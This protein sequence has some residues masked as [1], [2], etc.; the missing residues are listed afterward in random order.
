MT[1][2]LLPVSLLIM[3]E[4]QNNPPKVVFWYKLYCAAMIVLHFLVL[5]MGVIFII[6]H[7]SIQEN[8]PDGML[9]AGIVY[10]IIGFVFMIPFIVAFFL[11]RKSWVWIYHL[12]LICLGMLSCCCLP[13][14]VPLLIFWLKPD[15]KAYFR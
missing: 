4:N 13:A 5:V 2:A 3:I 12:V 10:A 8:D 6:F 11:P 1:N 9:M 7:K 15:V 14:S